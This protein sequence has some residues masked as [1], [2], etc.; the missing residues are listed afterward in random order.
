MAKRV[1]TTHELAEFLEKFS[2]LLQIY[3]DMPVTML[4]DIIRH[5]LDNHR[6]QNRT[7][8]IPLYLSNESFGF[9][10]DIPK[11]EI[12]SIIENNS[13]PVKWSKSDSTRVL[14]RRLKNYLD[15]HP[16]VDV[17][18]QSSSLANALRLLRNMK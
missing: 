17:R 13:I 4:F 12:I 15:D 6:N 9:F 1:M 3:P 8:E 11:S 2:S 14:A 18:P 10:N 5:S 16:E 7:S